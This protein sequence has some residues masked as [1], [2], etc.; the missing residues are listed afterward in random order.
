MGLSEQGNREFC[1]KFSTLKCMLKYSTYDCLKFNDKKKDFKTWFLNFKMCFATHWMIP[2]WRICQKS[3]EILRQFVLK[4]KTKKFSRG[5][6]QLKTKFSNHSNL[7]TQRSCMC[8]CIMMWSWSVGKSGQ[9][10]L[11]SSLWTKNLISIQKFDFFNIR[12]AGNGY[13]VSIT[14]LDR[15]IIIVFLFHNF[16]IYSVFSYSQ[17]YIH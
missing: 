14:Y 2:E 13:F 5:K 10:E 8:V 6:K 12:K 4:T 16:F 7:H 1:R 9:S 17:E 11:I 15:C 3:S